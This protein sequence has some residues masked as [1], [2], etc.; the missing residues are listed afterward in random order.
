VTGARWTVT[1][2]IYAVLLS[3][4]DGHQTLV[5]WARTASAVGLVVDAP[6]GKIYRMDMSGHLSIT[7]GDG[8]FSLAGATCDDRDGCAV[9]GPPLV[10]M[11]PPGEVSLRAGEAPL[12]WQTGTP[13]SSLSA[14]S[15]S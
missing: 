15:E 7:V 14:E 4:A 1:P 5:A 6:A 12:V 13:A 8:S 10:M 2:E 3:H 11:L 9:G